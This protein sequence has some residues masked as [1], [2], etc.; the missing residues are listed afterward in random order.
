MKSKKT[1]PGA[2][3]ALKKLGIGTVMLSGDKA[4]MVANVGQQLGIDRSYGGL[5]P[6]DKVAI[7]QTQR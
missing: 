6:E 3:S 4:A 1:L 5:L 7:V 2:I